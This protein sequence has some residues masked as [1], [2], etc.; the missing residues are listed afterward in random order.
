MDKKELDKKQ[1]AL[2][3]YIKEGQAKERLSSTEERILWDHI[4]RENR[5]YDKKRKLYLFSLSISVA[6]CLV[7]LWLIGWDK[8]QPEEPAVDYLSILQSTEQ[9]HLD[10]DQIQL[11]LSDNQ[12]LA[13]QGKESTINYQPDGEIQ[14]NEEILSVKKEEQPDKQQEEV[15]EQTFNQLIVPIGKRSFLTLTDGT[16]IWVNSGSRVIYPTHFKENKREIFVEGEVFL[17][18]THNETPFIVKTSQLDV[19]VLGTEFNISACA[20]DPSV[21][22]VL[23]HGEV[24]VKTQMD[25]KSLLSPNQ[26]FSYDKSAQKSRIDEVN[27]ADYVAWKDGYYQFRSQTIDIVLKRIS[28][29]YGLKLDWNEEVGKLRCSGKLDLKEN[30]IDVLNALSKAAPIEINTE[31]E[32]IQIKVKL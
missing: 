17:D 8:M 18:V 21:D 31:N 23:V 14:V 25:E 13:I 1:N 9:E 26:L 7:L 32:I 16:K 6:A 27:V 12:K 4:Q 10:S 22:V 24:A 20:D 19:T 30:P 28:R 3:T 5:K 15:K 2:L 11:V 29:Y